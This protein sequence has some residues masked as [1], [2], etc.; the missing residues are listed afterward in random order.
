MKGDHTGGVSLSVLFRTTR[1]NESLIQGLE[2]L[3]EEAEEIAQQHLP[4]EKREARESWNR[5]CEQALEGGEQWGHAYTKIA[6]EKKEQVFHT[7][8]D[9]Q[10]TA[11]P[12]AALAY[13]VALWSEAW[14]ARET[15][16]PAT[17]R[18]PAM[19][20]PEAPT[21]DELRNFSPPSIL[22]R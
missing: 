3:G 20:I 4:R 18:W 5:R 16:K 9:G 15:R 17:L 22:T 19:Q 14:N 8:E 11:C 7:C 21:I 10:P 6:E 13:Q 12:T 2:A 1:S